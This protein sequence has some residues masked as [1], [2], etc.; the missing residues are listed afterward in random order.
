MTLGDGLLWGIRLVERLKTKENPK[1][2]NNI[3]DLPDFTGLIFGGDAGN[4]ITS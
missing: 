2:L 4:I 3:R 1:V